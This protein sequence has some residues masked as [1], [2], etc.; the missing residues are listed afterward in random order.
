MPRA[1][2]SQA[3]PRREVRY[4]RARPAEHDGHRAEHDVHD[5]QAEQTEDEGGDGHAI[6][7]LVTDTAA[8]QDEF[9]GQALR[10]DEMRSRTAKTISQRPMAPADGEGDRE[11]EVRR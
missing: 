8:I 6:G 1:S 7:V 2:P 11:R 4:R 5:Q 10:C 3:R 9:H